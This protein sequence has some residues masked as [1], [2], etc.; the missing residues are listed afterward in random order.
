MSFNRSRDMV[1]AILGGVAIVLVSQWPAQQ[2]L[3]TLEREVAQLRVELAQAR[4]TV[5]PPTPEQRDSQPSAAL[6]VAQASPA[7]TP[8]AAVEQPAQVPPELHLAKAMA[9]DPELMVLTEDDLDSVVAGAG[10]PAPGMAGV[11][12]AQAAAPTPARVDNGGVEQEGASRIIQRVEKGGVLLRKG[13]LQVEPT[14]SYSHVSNNRVGL[15]GLSLFDVIFIGEIR[16]DEID[17]DI[18]TGSVSTRYGI[19]NNLQAEV[20]VPVQY[21]RE[22]VLSGPI[23]DRQQ[24]IN[25]RYGLNDLGL[26]FLYQF[27][28]EHGLMPNLI[29]QLRLKAPT[30]DAPK[31]GSGAWGTKAGLTMV[32]SS[33][34]VVLFSNMGYTLNFPGTVNGIDVNPGDAFEYSVGMA[35]ALNYKLALNGSFEQV[36]IGESK[37]RSAPVIG[38]R[39]VVASLKTGLTYAI[40]RKLAVDFSVSTGLTEDAPDFTVSLSFPYTF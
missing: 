21:Q 31:L 40:T 28:H 15:S 35:Y 14:L 19:T 1:L 8:S 39:L 3:K 32:K 17:R 22:E 25:R 13:R 18:V 29:A 24:S 33:D 2:R 38:S 16:S 20:E 5:A 30:G 37:A 9:A 12:A 10:P 7:T 23:E 34:P 26:G 6:S 36:F 27:V 11:V 4:T